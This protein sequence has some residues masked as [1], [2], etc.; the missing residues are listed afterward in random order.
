[1][2]ARGTAANAF[3]LLGDPWAAQRL[4][5]EL[6]GLFQGFT[7][8]PRL[9]AQVRG[10]HASVCVQVAR[11]ARAG[12]DGAA[13]DDAFD[14]AEASIART[15][16]IAAATGEARIAAFADVHAAE[17]ALLRARGREAL[18]L[19]G[20][21]VA[22][23]EARGLPAHLR[24]LRLLEAEALLVQGEAPAA[25]HRLAAVAASVTPRHELAV[26]IRLHA[27]LHDAHLHTGAEA[28]AREHLARARG[29][30]ALRHFR[31]LH[32]QSRFARTRLE[33]EHL[34]RYRDG[35]PR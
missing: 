32:A 26:R 2:R 5:S 12:G 16:E 28:A 10:N 24:Q 9:E 14:L 6:I 11:M 17:C 8:E 35:A 18:A 31:Q 22:Q 33:L 30:E 7:N 1:V 19:L 4:L 25:L 21:A 13:S 23:A 15:R 29:L 20:P 3:A 34:Y 27:L